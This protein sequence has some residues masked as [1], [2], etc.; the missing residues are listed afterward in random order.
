MF[1]PATKTVLIVE[2][3]IQEDVIDRIEAGGAKG[4]TIVPG[5][6]QG[7]HHRRRGRGAHIVD[8]FSIVR[9][10]FIMADDAKARAIA[11]DVAE[12]YFEQYPGIV[13][14]SPVEV[15]RPERF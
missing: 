1:S 3:L 12:R 14:I 2:R 5:S 8:D 4:Y 6:G 15:I 9:I 11:E 13:Y 10:E 7:E